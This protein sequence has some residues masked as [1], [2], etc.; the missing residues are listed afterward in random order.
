VGKT[1]VSSSMIDKVVQ[2]MGGMLYEVPVGFKWFVDGLASGQLIYGGE[3]SAGASFLRMN[4]QTWTTDKD[5][6]SSVLLA[7]EIMAR[8][9]L[10]PSEI[11]FGKLV[12]EHGE[13]YYGRHDF[14]LADKDA[15]AF[16]QIV[17]DLPTTIQPGMTIANQKVVQVL[18]K[19]P[20]NG[21][22]IGGIKV[23]LEDGSWFAV[24]P[25]GTEPKGKLYIESF[26]G[27]DHWQQIFNEV[28][29]RLIP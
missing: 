23:V 9:G 17:I 28:M 13:P 10:T 19:A 26:Q 7:A 11:Y 24:R 12:A 2:H 8:T 6:F 29:P 4:G 5:G 14:V 20:G 25:S 22:S 21:A 16:K 3:E 1:I 15:P 27:K 18:T